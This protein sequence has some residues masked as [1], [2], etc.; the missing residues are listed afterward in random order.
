M[1]KKYVCIPR[2]FLVNNICNQ[3][4]TLCSPCI[5]IYKIYS[6]THLSVKLWDMMWNIFNINCWTESCVTLYIFIYSYIL[7]SV[8]GETRRSGNQFAIMITVLR[9]RQVVSK[10]QLKCDGT[11][12][13]TGGEV[14]GNLENG[15]GIQ[16][17][18]HYLGTWC[19]QHYYLWWRTPRLTVVDWT[20]ASPADLNG[21]VRFAR[22]AKSGFCAC[23]ITFQ[24]QSKTDVT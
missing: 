10:V 4:K 7:L 16:Y 6:L 3:G 2:S 11:R 15:M 22:K 14:K 1:V 5:S 24:T 12:W 21:L 23:A 13:R 8:D 18:L 19:I 9:A 17:S 20:D